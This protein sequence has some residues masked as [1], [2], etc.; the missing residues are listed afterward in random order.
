VFIFLL[1][2]M[3]YLHLT[4]S[5]LISS[6]TTNTNGFISVLFIAKKTLVLLTTFQEE[7]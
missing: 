7:W 6:D 3:G 2:G 1:R 5:E 4:N